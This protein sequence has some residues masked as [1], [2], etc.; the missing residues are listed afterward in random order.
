MR[1]QGWQTACSPAAPGQDMLVQP[2]ARLASRQG[3]ERLRACVVCRPAGGHLAAAGREAGADPWLPAEAVAVAWRRARRPAAAAARQSGPAGTDSRGP[4][5]PAARGRGKKRCRCGL[6]LAATLPRAGPESHRHRVPH[7]PQQRQSCRVAGN[8]ARGRS[9]V[10]EG[11]QAQTAARRGHT[12]WPPALLSVNRRLAGGGC[13]SGGG[14]AGA[15]WAG[16]GCASGGGWAGG[17]GPR[18]W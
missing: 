7:A 10:W 17:G 4:C 3:S 9:N 8:P 13:V 2:A 16:G 6:S 11:W 14:W 18:G 5:G 15:G 1:Q 12:C